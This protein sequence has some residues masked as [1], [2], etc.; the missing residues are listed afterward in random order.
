ME[1]R[2]SRSIAILKDIILFSIALIDS[3]ITPKESLYIA[4]QKDCV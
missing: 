3:Y 4:R 1:L 2:P